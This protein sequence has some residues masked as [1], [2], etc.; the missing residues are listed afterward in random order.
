[1]NCVD[2]NMD[3]VTCKFQLQLSVAGASGNAIE[4]LSVILQR[5]RGPNAF[6]NSISFTS[7]LTWKTQNN[8]EKHQTTKNDSV[9]FNMDFLL[10]FV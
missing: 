4:S 8:S 5:S 9:S 2:M 1:M 7:W 6:Q 10:V 3:T